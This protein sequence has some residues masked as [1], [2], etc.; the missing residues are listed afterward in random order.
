[1]IRRDTL[2]L[3]VTGYGSSMTP[4]MRDRLDKTVAFCNGKHP[5]V[6]IFT[7]GF[8]QRSVPQSEASMMADYVCPRLNYTP[9]IV[10]EDKSHTT[11]ENFKFCASWLKTW[12]KYKDQTLIVDCEVTRRAS[13]IL[14]SLVY[15][16]KLPRVE[17]SSWMPRYFGL[18]E[19]V[20]VGYNLA[21]LTIPGFAG[22]MRG[23]RL[24]R[25]ER[26]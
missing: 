17:T 23:S 10:L 25:A 19:L 13:V 16:R 20:L 1:M 14:L 9:L 21:Q 26:S 18:H 2:I 12:P 8:T 3:I 4:E 22:W 11:L 6:I 24:Q 7:G 15:M 5:S